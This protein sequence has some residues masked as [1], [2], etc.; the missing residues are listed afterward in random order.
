MDVSLM[1]QRPA[2]AP[3]VQFGR[4][5]PHVH[6]RYAYAG[7]TRGTF[8]TN[9]EWLPLLDA[10]RAGELNRLGTIVHPDSDD[11]LWTVYRRGIRSGRAGR[12]GGDVVVAVN[13]AYRKT[14]RFPNEIWEQI[15]A[16]MKSGAL[17]DLPCG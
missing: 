11:G 1:W 15:L 8:Y 6:I 17:T 12:I 3:D 10:V 4:D 9:E 14:D 7:E 16:A 5:G 2:C 13:Y